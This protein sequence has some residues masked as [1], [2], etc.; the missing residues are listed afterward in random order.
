M[1][2]DETTKELGKA[3][4]AWKENEK[5]KNKYRD[6][7]FREVTEAISDELPAKSVQKVTAKDIEE[8]LRISQ[9]RFSR[10]KVIDCVDLGDGEFGVVLED[11]PEFRPFTYINK[12]DG[13][14]YSRVIA[15]GTPY[16][17]DEGM[18]DEDPELWEKIT[19]E[20]T[21][22]VLKPLDSMS[23]E[24]LAQI[25]PY[26]VTPKPTVRLGNPRIAKQEE[27]DEDDN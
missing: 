20:K 4:A 24:E 21:E 5:E 7:F 6:K 26:L 3:H 23:A 19:V 25:Q 10:H 12:I 18:R 1:A 27:L 11:D 17:D 22:R 8:A 9:R 13:K 2:L 14:V 15:E 16:L